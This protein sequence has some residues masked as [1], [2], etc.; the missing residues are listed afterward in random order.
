MYISPCLVGQHCQVSCGKQ[1]H[2]PS[3][4]KGGK[5]RQRPLGINAGL[6]PGAALHSKGRQQQQQSKAAPKGGAQPSKRPRLEQFDD[7]QQP[8]AASSPQQKQQKRP[9][10]KPAAS[11]GAVPAMQHRNGAS[12]TAQQQHKQ[13][14]HQAAHMPLSGKLSILLSGQPKVNHAANMA[15]DP[16]SDV[17]QPKPGQPV[18]KRA[19]GGRKRRKK[20]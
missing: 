1:I 15:S 20:G 4:G 10:V 14:R 2:P 11:A 12:N 9:L 17:T 19:E 13:Q 16:I 7:R 8:V 3:V 18:R 5:Q 6:K